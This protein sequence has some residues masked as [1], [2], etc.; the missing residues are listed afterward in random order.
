M[1]IRNI[2]KIK[3]IIFLI[4][5]PMSKSNTKTNWYPYISFI[6]GSLL[7]I[8]E[9]LPFF[10]NSYGNGILHSLSKILQEYKQNFH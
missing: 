3:K 8:S 2:Y 4:K 7:T 5:T 1:Y 10:N 9:T 6:S